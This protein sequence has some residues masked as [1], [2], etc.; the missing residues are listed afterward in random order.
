[1]TRPNIDRSN[2]PQDEAIMPKPVPG[3]ELCEKT[4][5]FADYWKK[6]AWHEPSRESAI[7]CMEQAS[8]GWKNLAYDLA[9]QVHFAMKAQQARQY[10]EN[11]KRPA[12]S[13]E[14]IY[15]EALAVAMNETMGAQQDSHR[16][17]LVNVYASGKREASSPSSE[18]TAIELPEGHRLIPL[19]ILKALWRGEPDAMRWVRVVLGILDDGTPSSAGRTTSAA[20]RVDALLAEIDAPM[21]LS[22]S[23]HRLRD[24]AH[25]LAGELDA[26]EWKAEHRL[27]MFNQREQ[28]LRDLQ[29]AAMRAPQSATRRITA[30]PL[31]KKLSE[32]RDECAD[33]LRRLTAVVENNF[34]MPA[35]VH[36]DSPLD[37][38]RKA[39]AKV[40]TY[41]ERL[42]NICDG[43]G[44][45]Y[46]TLMARMSGSA[47]REMNR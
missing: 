42:R 47:D 26:A 17:A 22:E 28:L 13:I 18:S 2:T 4:E 29:A 16:A 34:P 3:A 46:D 11:I 45:D 39:L 15:D 24:F 41:E 30:M 36:P 25:Q 44:L 35:G 32:Q 19:A 14:R 5:T 33:A 7:I 12:D 21:G 43:V 20:S 27:A 9:R 8:N 23:W 10:S 40:P 37:A 1:M 31:I 6:G 38:A